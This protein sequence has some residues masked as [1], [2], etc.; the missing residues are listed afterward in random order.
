MYVGIVT[1]RATESAITS[2]RGTQP[3]KSIRHP[4]PEIMPPVGWT[5]DVRM[6]LARVTGMCSLSGWSA[7][8]VRSSGWNCAASA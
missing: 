7:A 3:F 5:N 1:L 6:P 8:L 4:W 2:S